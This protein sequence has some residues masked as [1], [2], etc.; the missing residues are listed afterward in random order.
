MDDEKQHSEE[1]RELSETKKRPQ[2]PPPADLQLLEGLTIGPDW[3]A[4]GYVSPPAK[5]GGAERRPGGQRRGPGLLH[6]DRRGR[7]PGGG[8]GKASEERGR[9]DRRQSVRRYPERQPQMRPTVDVQ[10]FPEETPFLAVAQAMRQS[11]RTYKLFDLAQLVLAKPERYSV[12]VRPLKSGRIEEK[13]G[14]LYISVPDGLPFE[15]EADAIDHVLK[16]YLDE[17]FRVESVE[18]EPPGG[19]FQAVNRCGFTGVLLGPPN[20]HRYAKMEREHHAERVS[21]VSFENFRGRIESVRDPEVIAQWVAEMTTQQ[22]YF[23]NPAVDGECVD[24]FASL[25]EAKRFLLNRKRELVVSESATARFQ[26]R[27][28]DRLPPGQSV[29]R[30]VELAVQNQ[31]RFPMDTANHIRG[32]FKRMRFN[33]YKKG[34]GGISYV[35]AVKRRFREPE[36]VFADDVQLLIEFIEKHPEIPALK[37]PEDFLGMKSR[38]EIAGKGPAEAGLQG[39]AVSDEARLGSLAQNLRWLVAEGYVVEYADGRLF[40]PPLRTPQGK[41]A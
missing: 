19:N 11:N 7:P 35:C 1:P 33:V 13:A 39:D 31:M 32:R 9:S 38:S 12:V 10:I 36:E 17:F 23:P 8:G 29:R 22:R 6:R 26:G 16:H 21:Q 24:G 3:S 20:Y 2:D 41:K 37:L 14:R 4:P 27:Y 25:E 28:L 5:T 40:A 34:S 30:S 15:S 18:V